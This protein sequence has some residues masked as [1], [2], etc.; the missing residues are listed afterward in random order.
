M[1]PLTIALAVETKE[2]WDEI[3][4]CVQPLPVRSVI[5]HRERGQDE[6][7]LDRLRRMRPDVVVLDISTRT[8]PLEELVR[9][10]R[11]AS[12]D[13]MI[14]A[15]HTSADT[16]IILSSLRAGVN[17]YLYPPLGESLRKA[18]ERKSN[19]RSRRRDG[20]HDGGRCIAFFSA[21]G[22][23]GATTVAVHA[24]VE[25]GRLG[26][27][28]M[29]MDLDMDTGLIAFLLKTKSPYSIL[30]AFNNLHRLD[31]SYWKALVSN[32]IPGLDIISAPGA[33]TTFQQIGHEQLRTVLGFVRSQYDFAI[34]D[35]GRGLS[36]LSMSALGEVDEACLVTTLE[37]PALH[38]TKQIVQRL[39]DTG[40]AKAR[41]KLILNKVPKRLDVTPEELEKMLGVP[42]HSM[43]PDE[44]PDLYE[45]Y[46]EGR[47]LPRTS[48]LGRHLSR[49]AGKLAG[50]DE[51]KSKSRFSLFG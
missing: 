41:L 16:G 2:L 7:F 1:Y 3:Q 14:A 44:Y 38:H 33:S 31:A 11:S 48:A 17:E 15:V 40:Y 46:A 32:G 4:H 9:T 28:V 50:L 35:L 36:R 22:G 34:L 13:S 5:E 8:G 20:A 39:H 10:L 29:L 49:V 12:P 18:L 42:V 21:K 26:K 45:C 24:A 43:L 23:C 19:E 27:S 47:L 51:E 37:V 25:L 6:V 30:D